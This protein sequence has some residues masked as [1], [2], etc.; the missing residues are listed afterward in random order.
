LLVSLGQW[1]NVATPVASGLLAIASAAV[2]EDF[3]VTG[4]TIKSLELQSLTAE[5][6]MQLLKSGL[7]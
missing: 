5:N 4:R 1:A 3:G 7:T 6:M 2:G